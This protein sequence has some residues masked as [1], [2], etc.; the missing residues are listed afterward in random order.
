MKTL[1]FLFLILITTSTAYA[2]EFST[3][4]NTTYSILPT[5][6]ALVEQNIKITN[7]EKDVIATDYALIIRQLNI[8]DVQVKDDK[9]IN[10]DVDTDNEKSVIK[11][12]FSKFAIGQYKS[13]EFTITYKTKDIAGIV[14]DVVNISIPKIANLEQVNEYNI[15]LIVP[16]SLGPLLYVSP[17][18]LSQEEDEETRTF[19][20][21]KTILNNIG[22]DAAFGQ[23]QALN[24]KLDYILYNDSFFTKNMQIALPPSIKD[25]QVVT[26][27]TLNPRPYNIEIDKDGNHLA[28]YRLGA[29]QTLTITA[30]GNAQVLGKQIIPAFGGKFED[31]PKELIRSYTKHQPYWESDN[32]K[33][34]GIA[35][36]LKDPNKTVSQNAQIIYDYVGQNLKY[37]FNLVRN[38]FIERHGAL[39]AL[40]ENKSWACMEF[41]DTFIAIARAM[42]IPARELNGYAYSGESVNKPISIGFKSGDVLHAWPE[43]YDPKFGWVAIDPTWGST[44]GL[45]YFTRLDTNHFVFVRK[46]TNSVY[47][48][49]AGAYKLNGSEK[50]VEVEFAL[51]QT[52][53]DTKVKL[54]QYTTVLINPLRF[55]KQERPYFFSNNGNRT[56]T[57]NSV[58][59][60][61]FAH[62]KIYVK[63]TDLTSSQNVLIEQSSSYKFLLGDIRQSFTFYIIAFVVALVPCTILLVLITHLKDLRT[64]ISRLLRHPQDPSQ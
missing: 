32:P 52:D 21:N 49:P 6:E 38:E 60:P 46:G 53:I 58:D 27:T 47:P 43:F 4:Y 64:L 29:K 25:K 50:Q 20:F 19:F 13:K 17:N 33:I 5:N 28:K 1:F 30:A 34:K 11:V 14:G 51:E 57:L 10:L 3:S 16:K 9:D 12:T 42:G 59:L 48:L 45:D 23:T 54:T 63:K 37:D 26:Y 2:N 18:P 39:R 55:L 36:K 44:S 56:V 31:I 61:P 24:F 8:Y 35:S 41:T 62:K 15:K 7:Q 22:I 40:S